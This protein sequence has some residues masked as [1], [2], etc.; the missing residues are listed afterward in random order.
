VSTVPGAFRPVISSQADEALMAERLISHAA[1]LYQLR[2]RTGKTI[3]LAL[4]PEP[5]CYIE[6]IAEAVAFFE[7]HL[8][9]R[10]AVARF[11]SLAGASL[12]ESEGALR[13]H[14]GVCL[15]A[16]HAAVEFEEPRSALDALDRAGIHVGKIQLSAG[17]E[18]DF[19]AAGDKLALLDELR[20]FAEGV[21]L[22]QVVARV[23][24]AFYHT[25][26]LPEAIAE[27]ERNPSRL[28]VW[29]IHFHVPI[30][31]E[32]L[33]PFRNTQP[34]LIDLLSIVRER[35]V[36]EHLEVET[37]TWDVLPEEYRR[38]AINEA[39]ARELSWVREKLAT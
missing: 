3:T 23:D 20:P 30:F 22:H 9:T 24:R 18:V 25:L 32:A 39:V 37:Y 6:T 8:F 5:F 13:R 29:R 14:L 33:G 36:S 11:S 26:D 34:L 17:L 4:E 2:E 28:G 21:Y 27:A 7:S 31:R 1:F 12:R 10:A 19:D 15:D 38:E 35:S 16:C